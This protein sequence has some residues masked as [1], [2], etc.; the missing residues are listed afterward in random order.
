[1]KVEFYIGSKVH[2]CLA[3]P[4]TFETIDEWDAFSV[5]LALNSL[6]LGNKDLLLVIF[7]KGLKT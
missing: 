1:M 7:V 2:K 4:S 5:S 3:R 6:D